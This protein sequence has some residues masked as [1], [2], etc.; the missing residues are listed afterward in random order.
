MKKL[1]KLTALL[2]A[3]VSALSLGALTA[4]DN[5]KN[6]KLSFFSA[7]EYSALGGIGILESYDGGVSLLSKSEQKTNKTYTETDSNKQEIIANLNVAKNLIGGDLVKSE[8]KE[9][10][11]EGYEKEYTLSVSDIKGEDKI[12][13]FYY[14]QILEEEEEDEKE[15]LLTGIVKVGEETYKLVGESEIEQDEEE[16]SFKVSIDQDNYVEIESEKEGNGFE[17]SYKAVQNG[18]EVY[19]NEVEYKVGKNG[20]VGIEFSVE[21]NGVEIEYEYVFYTKNDENFVKVEI[22]KDDDREEKALIKIT[23]DELGNIQYEFIENQSL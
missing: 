11:L 8:V 22:E 17:F 5:D 19:E 16:Y 23:Q 3:G 1:N 14:N 12:Y 9:S 7:Y 6:G 21:E 20:K 10:T 4:C 18:Q 15:Y 2:V 13:N